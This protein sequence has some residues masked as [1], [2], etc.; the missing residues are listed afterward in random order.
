[1]SNIF[2]RL[3]ERAT[4]MRMPRSMRRPVTI[5]VDSEKTGEVRHYMLDANEEYELTCKVR[6]TFW[7]NSAQ[8]FQERRFAE[9]A[10]SSF[11]YRDVLEVLGR[12]EHAVSDG[13]ANDALRLCGELREAIA[14]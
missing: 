2:E 10:L 1:M 14:P 6:V 3:E 11:L 7:A 4:G 9:R 12:I 13:D 8:R 5:E